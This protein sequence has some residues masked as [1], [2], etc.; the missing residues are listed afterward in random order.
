MNLNAALYE[1]YLNALMDARSKR[2][3]RE[4]E[5]QA[6][7][8]EAYQRDIEPYIKIKLRIL[9]RHMPTYTVFLDASG[10]WEVKQGYEFSP[11]VQKML[12][13]LDKMIDGVAK[14]YN[15]EIPTCSGSATESR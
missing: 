13:T 6:R 1:N 12:D 7:K 11:E 15:L 8:I 9:E 4:S 2:D 5:M 3:R 10:T 14:A